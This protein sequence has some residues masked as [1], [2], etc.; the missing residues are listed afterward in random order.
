MT[1]DL[2]D[3]SR[4]NLLGN[5]LRK[6]IEEA[7]RRI[8]EQVAPALRG[9]AAFAR[10]PPLPQPKVVPPRRLRPDAGVL[11]AVEDEA[12]RFRVDL[13]ARPLAVGQSAKVV[14][15]VLAEPL[16]LVRVNAEHLAAATGECPVDRSDLIWHPGQEVLWCPG[17][18]SQWRLDGHVVRGPARQRQ[19]ALHVVEMEGVARIDVP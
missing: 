4:R 17:C 5:L 13:A 10:Q 7:T 19:L 9:A 12:G 16:V 15:D 2:P 6:P 3:P 14:A 11:R 1:D 18:G 8:P